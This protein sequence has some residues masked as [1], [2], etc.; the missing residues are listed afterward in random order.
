MAPPSCLR[1]TAKLDL[2]PGPPAPRALGDAPEQLVLQRVP[3]SCLSTGPRGD[4]GPVWGLRSGARA[5]SSGRGGAVGGTLP[6]T[7]HS[8]ELTVNGVNKVSPPPVSLS[9]CLGLGGASVWEPRPW[10]TCPGVAGP[11]PGAHRGP[12]PCPSSLVRGAPGVLSC[13]D[14]CA[15]PPLGPLDPEQTPAPWQR[16]EVGGVKETPG[17]PESWDSRQG[18]AETGWQDFQG[19]PGAPRSPHGP[20]LA[21]LHRAGRWAAPPSSDPTMAGPGVYSPGQGGLSTAAGPRLAP[22]P[23]TWGCTQDAH[24]LAFP[25]TSP[26]GLVAPAAPPHFPRGLRAHVCSGEGALRRPGAAPRGHWAALPACQEHAW[27]EERTG[28]WCVFLPPSPGSGRSRCLLSAY[29]FV[30]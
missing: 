13:P 24:S 30:P 10:G 7:L 25:P 5:G 21:S 9:V 18:E 1:P 6:P 17:H 29:G 16:Q 27:A 28:T 20:T 15:P 4:G 23:S 12:Q 26:S 22:A 19:E 8:S 14:V 11:P 2:P 3:V